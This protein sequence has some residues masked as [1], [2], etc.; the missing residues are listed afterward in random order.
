MNN[1]QHCWTSKINDQERSSLTTMNPQNHPT[2]NTTNRTRIILRA[3]IMCEKLSPLKI[4]PAGPFHV[5][6]TL[7]LI[8]LLKYCD[9]NEYRVSRRLSGFFVSTARPFWGKTCRGMYG[10]SRKSHRLSSS[11]IPGN[12]GNALVRVSRTGTGR[13]GNIYVSH[14]RV[15]YYILYISEAFDGMPLIK[16]G[17]KAEWENI[18]LYSLSVRRLRSIERA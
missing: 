13:R 8:R 14:R 4:F 17:N 6:P 9:A 11:F 15:P 12:N 16:K 5:R 18:Q 7:R 2:N 10:E 1:H 3:S